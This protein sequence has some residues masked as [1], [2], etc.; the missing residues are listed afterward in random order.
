MVPQ[1]SFCCRALSDSEM[2]NAI[3]KLLGLY[4]D[5]YLEKKREREVV[6]YNDV[7]QMALRD[8]ERE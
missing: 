2:I 3:Y 4:R 1:L 5:L 6:T 7:A 8:P